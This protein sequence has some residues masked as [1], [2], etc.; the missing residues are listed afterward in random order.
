MQRGVQVSDSEPRWD[1]LLARGE[2]LGVDV[3]SLP[4]LQPLQN[5]HLNVQLADKLNKAVEAAAAGRAGPLSVMVQVSARDGATG[6]EQ[7]M[8]RGLIHGLCDV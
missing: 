4:V 6:Q 2:R 7:A 1:R 3:D 5:T 8:G